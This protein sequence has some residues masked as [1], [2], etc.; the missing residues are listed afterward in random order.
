MFHSTDTRKVFF[1]SRETFLKTISLV[2]LTVLVPLRS[3]MMK[4]NKIF[5]VAIYACMVFKDNYEL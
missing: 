3:F 1:I 5:L 4:T 2:V